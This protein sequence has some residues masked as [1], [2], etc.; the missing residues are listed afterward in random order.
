MHEFICP[1]NSIKSEWINLVEN[2]IETC[3]NISEIQIYT[4]DNNIIQDNI[5]DELASNSNN[6]SNNNSIK[7]SNNNNSNNNSIKNDNSIKI[8]GININN[9]I[10]YNNNN[11]NNNNNSPELITPNS[12]ND[13]LMNITTNIVICIKYLGLTYGHTLC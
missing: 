11:N 13:D 7:N 5:I 12:S 6:N 8:N 4:P 3:S 2:A 9:N 1:T 10:N